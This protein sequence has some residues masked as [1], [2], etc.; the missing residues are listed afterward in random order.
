MVHVP[1]EHADV[2]LRH[3][4]LASLAEKLGFAFESVEHL[5]H[6]FLHVVELVRMLGKELLDAQLELLQLADRRRRSL[7]QAH[8]A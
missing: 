6:D 1:L 8:E 4:R 7:D 3:G 5:P 2:P